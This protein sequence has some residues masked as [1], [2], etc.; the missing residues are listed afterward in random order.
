MFQDFRWDAEDRKFGQPRAAFNPQALPWPSAEANEPAAADIRQGMFETLPVG[1]GI[2]LKDAV[3]DTFDLDSVMIL[4]ARGVTQVAVADLPPVLQGFFYFDPHKI[5]QTKERQNAE[6]EW[7]AQR[8]T[9]NRA[10]RPVPDRPEPQYAG[11]RPG[12]PPSNVDDLITERLRQYTASP[13]T[14]VV[15][16]Q[17]PVF[18]NYYDA[19]KVEFEYTMY[20]SDGRTPGGRRIE[21]TSYAWFRDKLMVRWRDITPPR[22]PY[23][24]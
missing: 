8:A 5:A 16:T 20:Y 13:G 21:G 12:Q 22:S 17:S 9:A 18:D 6:V 11:D 10:P 19:W 15:K 2:T 7:R 3:L 23:L 1:A 24:N 14:I 4:H